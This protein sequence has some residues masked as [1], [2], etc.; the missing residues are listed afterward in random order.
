MTDPGT[1]PKG[2]LIR[3]AACIFQPFP[4]PVSPE[5]LAYFDSA[6]VEK[7][8][9]YA[10]ARY[11]SFAAGTSFRAS[12]TICNFC[13]GDHCF[14]GMGDVLL[15]LLKVFR[16]WCRLSPA[17]SCRISWVHYSRRLGL[18]WAQNNQGVTALKSN[19]PLFI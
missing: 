2:L 1:I 6:Q 13:S 9:I 8:A 16:G 17:K 14:F 12:K 11:L 7:G 3:A 10:R 4:R 19:N 18:F 5:A 15:S